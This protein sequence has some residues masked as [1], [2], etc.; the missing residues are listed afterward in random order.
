MVTCC[1]IA[2]TKEKHQCN[3][4]HYAAVNFK[5]PLKIS[6]AKCWQ[7]CLGLNMLNVPSNRTTSIVMIVPFIQQNI[8][9]VACLKEPSLLFIYTVR[10][11]GKLTWK[12]DVFQMLLYTRYIW[13][14]IKHSILTQRQCQT[15]TSVVSNFLLM[16][17]HY[18]QK[19]HNKEVW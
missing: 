5:M 6:P 2:G 14:R 12:V 10:H 19:N 3:S 4:N 9:S 8:D 18:R 16:S 17:E 1:Q 11:M 7:F 15:C 13:Y